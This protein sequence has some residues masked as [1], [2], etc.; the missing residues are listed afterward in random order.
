MTE[1]DA[2]REQ[3]TQKYIQQ[4]REVLDRNRDNICGM[5]VL[6]EAA[7]AFLSPDEMIE[8]IDLFS[9]RWRQRD[10]M[11]ELRRMIEQRL[12]VAV[13]CAYVDITA[14]D[15]AGNETALSSVVA[16]PAVRYVLV[17]FWASW[18]APCM[19]EVPYLKEAY[20]NYRA[21]GFEIYGVSFD[22]DP[23]RLRSTLKNNDMQWIQVCDGKGFE[24]PAAENYAVESIPANFLIRT[25]DGEIVATQ[26][27]GAALGDKLAELLAE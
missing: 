1:A 23:E 2:D 27:R 26:L 24:S 20:A 12:R 21:R 4:M 22:T 14:P 17:D 5:I 18:C 19:M 11:V 9:D 8:Q 16:N 7:P 13:G 15:T 3:L 25:S 6:V 10:E